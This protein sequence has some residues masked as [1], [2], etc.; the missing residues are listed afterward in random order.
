MDVIVA[1]D[2]RLL[3]EHL[4]S[5]LRGAGYSVRA[6]RDGKAALAEFCSHRPDLLLLDVMM[7]GMGG[8]ET[9]EAVRQTDA[10]VPV[11]F[12][13][14]L[15]SETD[16]LN[17]LACGGDVFIPKTVSDEVLLA[18]IKAALRRR[19]GERDGVFSFEGWEIDAA[20]LSMTRQ[21]AGETTLNE[22]EIAILRWF[23]Q[24]P[25]EVFSK[26]FL[27]TRFWGVDF[28]G[29]Y[30]ALNT[31]ISRLR[32]KLGSDGAAIRSVHAVGYSYR[33]AHRVIG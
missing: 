10:D 20:K 11:L 21:G 9:C 31:A 16:E 1:E 26:D 19:Q 24:H 17:A 6:V 8:F 28:G 15:D 29:G 27:L 23:V 30:S 5:L 4:A 14:A 22:R 2:E 13:T 33:P 12:L 18:R 25:G 7:P 32:S 3:R